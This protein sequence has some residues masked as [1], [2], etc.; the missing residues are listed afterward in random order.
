M[1]SSPKLDNSPQSTASKTPSSSKKLVQARL[2]FKALSGSEPPVTTVSD[3]AIIADSTTKATENRKRKLPTPDDGA[4]APKINRL[5]ETNSIVDNDDLLTSETMEASIDLTIDEVKT[6]DDV[7][8]TVND[9]SFSR[10][11]ESKENVN[12]N[13]DVNET[14]KSKIDESMGTD[15]DV[16]LVDSDSEGP[17]AKQ[18]LEFSGRRSGTRKSKR[19]AE[20]NLI[21]IKLPMKKKSKKDKKLKKSQENDD[22]VNV[23]DSIVDNEEIGDEAKP[24]D[25][26]AKSSTSSDHDQT[27]DKSVLDESIVST[28]NSDDLDDKVVLPSTP[29][30]QNI[31]PKQ[32]LRRAESE[33]KQLEKQRAKEERERKL[34]EEREMRQRQK[35]EQLEMKK[36]EREEKGKFSFFCY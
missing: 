2:P 25:N 19:L 12:E 28:S 11:S 16:S 7:N 21:K 29:N 30:A 32:V 35:E 8:K 26:E 13:V 23:N 3:D 20:E 1:K 27:N 22:S 15:C 36:K 9:Q 14:N 5:N 31:T 18:S 33:K 24:E 17:K 10:N 34:Q 6:K 4:R